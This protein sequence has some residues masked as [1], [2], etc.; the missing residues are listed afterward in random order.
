ML[1]PF[2]LGVGGIMGSGRQWW[3]WI[4]LDDLLGAI[5]HALQ[6]GSVHGPVNGVSPN[7][8]TNRE[9]TKT[10]GKVLSRPTIFP[11][12]AFAAR[13]VLGGMV[14]ELILASSRV[15]P[16]LLLSSGYT[17]RH[18]DLEAGLRHVLGK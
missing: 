14:D 7:P 18:P 16:T 8:V 6:T 11:M 17:F 2:K 13:L 12:P 5:V 4:T 10:L 9:F 1:T 15:Q 3:S